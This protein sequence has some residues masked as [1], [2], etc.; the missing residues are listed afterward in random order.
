MHLILQLPAGTI[1]SESAYGWR[2]LDRNGAIL[3]EGTGPLGDAPRGDRLTVTIPANRVLFTELKLPPVSAA[4]LATLLPYAIE[5]KLM[6]DPAHILALAGAADA[7]G[8]R[9]VAV[10]DKPW[11]MQALQQL[12]T[13]SLTP[14]AVIPESELVPRAAGAWTANLPPGAREGVLVRDDGFALAFDMP[15]DP[16]PPLSVVLAIR[17]AGAHAPSRILACTAGEAEVSGWS[18]ALNLP[19]DWRSPALRVDAKTSFDFLSHDALRIFAKRSDWQTW[20][21]AFRPAAVVAGLI[22]LFHFASLAISVWQLDRQATALRQEMVA[23]FQ[24][25]FPD[26]KAIVD[27]ALQMSRNLADLRRERGQATDPIVPGLAAMQSWARAAGGDVRGVKF[28][29]RKLI[30]EIAFGAGA[31]AA[32][33]PAGLTWVANA[34]GKSGQLSW[35]AAR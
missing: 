11:L 3:R 34:D 6:S 8:F 15:S 19:V 22:A 16:T 23:T 24:S 30:A 32:P 13:A 31:P 14:D 29:G 35:E 10:V 25:A 7:E 21:P 5:D 28:D 9:V 33:A 20:W 26:A 4:R 27:P 2:L 17:E 12:R 1:T 18:T